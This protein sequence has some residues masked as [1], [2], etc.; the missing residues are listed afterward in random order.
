[1]L[2]LAP[3]SAHPATTIA[4]IIPKNIIILSFLYICCYP[5]FTL[6]EAL[7]GSIL[8]CL[9]KLVYLPRL[10]FLF[11]FTTSA[12]RAATTANVIPNTIIIVILSLLY[13]SLFIF[14]S[15]KVMPFCVRTQFFSRKMQKRLDFLIFIKSCHAKWSI[16]AYLLAKLIVQ[17]SFSLFIC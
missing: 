10:I 9:S 17:E 11:T 3:Y 4:K 16:M 13:Y 7:F 14:S 6:S 1:M 2:V 12:K 5:I 8:R 15:A